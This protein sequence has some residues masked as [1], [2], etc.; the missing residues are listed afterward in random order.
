MENPPTANGQSMS[1]VPYKMGLA[2][3]YVKT[4]LCIFKSWTDRD[5]SGLKPNFLPNCTLKTALQHTVNLKHHLY[6]QN[7]SDHTSWEIKVFCLVPAHACFHHKQQIALQVGQ[8][9]H[10]YDSCRN[11]INLQCPLLVEIKVQTTIPTRRTEIIPAAIFYV[12]EM[13]HCLAFP[14]FQ[15]LSHVL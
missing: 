12:L 4:A 2:Q 9:I 11:I 8:Q 3:T 10:M 13:T 7:S 5:A 14:K 6:T 15:Q 1:V